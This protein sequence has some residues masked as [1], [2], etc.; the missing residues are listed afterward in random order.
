[1]AKIYKFSIN[2]LQGE[3]VQL[4]DFAGK[5]L[6]LVNTASKCGL[7]PQYAELQALHQKYADQGLAVIGFPCNQFGGQEPGDAGQIQNDCLVNYGVDFLITEKID[8]NGPGAHPIFQ[9]IKEACP[10][11]VS[12]D[13]KWNFTKFLV[14]A[15]GTP[16]RRFA[17]VTSPRKLE[18]KIKRLLA[19]SRG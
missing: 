19:R 16:Q 18:G 15:D 5:V 8:V 10:G 4:A 1:M 17:P 11:L 12:N 6:L 14:A 3:P 13:I 2:S 7:T 9:Y